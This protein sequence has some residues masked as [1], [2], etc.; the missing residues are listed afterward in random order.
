M[1]LV[2]TNWNTGLFT[3]NNIRGAGS[4][5][6]SMLDRFLIYEKLM[7]T[8]KEVTTQVL[9]FGGSDHWPIQLEI[10]GIGT[11]KNKP[12][13]YENIWLTHP[14][15]INNIEK[16]WSEDLQIWGT[17]MYLLHKRQNHIKL[18]LNNVTRRILETFFR[19]NKWWR[20]K[21]R[22]STKL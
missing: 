8:D 3:W 10:K 14:N 20:E 4:H 21:C 9:S 1:N 5:M 15:F 16:W 18:H 17:R 13:R 7:L 6:A 11:P 2:D 12:F 22:F 19:R